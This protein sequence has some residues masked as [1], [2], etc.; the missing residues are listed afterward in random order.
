[1]ETRWQT[2]AFAGN[3]HDLG[4]GFHTRRSADRQSACGVVCGGEMQSC[5]LR[6]SE[7]VRQSLRVAAY[8]YPNSSR[9]EGKEQREAHA[10]SGGLE[11]SEQSAT[12]C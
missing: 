12:K 7:A 11:G 8:C 4:Q 5:G 1:M 10:L 2:L 3:R 9:G 6:A